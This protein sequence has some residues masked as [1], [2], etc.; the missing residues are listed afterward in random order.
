MGRTTK[1]LVLALTFS[2]I[3]AVP[4][5]QA[6]WMEDGVP[7]CS[8]VNNQINVE[9]ISDGSGGA[10]ITWE[11][12]GAGSKI[13]VQRI[14]NLGAVQWTENGKEICSNPAGQ[15]GQDLVLDDADGA[16][17][18]WTD[19][20]NGSLLSNPDIF[21]QRIDADGDTVWASDGVAIC[22]APGLQIV[23]RI[24]SDGAGGAIITWPDKRNG[25][26]DVYAQ[27]IDASGAVL[28][29]ADGDTVCVASG[30]Q[31]VPQIVSDDAGGAII[32]WTD[33]RNG[34]WDPYAQRIDGDCNGMWAPDGVPLCTHDSLQ[35]NEHIASDGAGNVLVTWAD[36]RNG[37]WD[38]YAQKID[39]SGVVHWGTNGT[40]VCT[41]SNDQEQPR[42]VTDD[43]GGAIIVWRDRRNG[44]S[45]IYAQ[46]LDAVVGIYKWTLDG[47]AVCTGSDSQ[48][49][50][51]AVADD[52]G[53][54]IVT[55][56]DERSGDVLPEDI[57]AQ[58]IDKD[59]NILW[60][61]AGLAVCTADWHQY[62]PEIASNGAGGA[63]I[64]WE[65][66]RDLFIG[67]D[68]DIYAQ[69]IDRHGYWGYPTPQILEIDDVPDDQGGKISIIWSAAQL[70]YYPMSIITHYSIWR[71]LSYEES[72]ALFE[73]Q[74]LTPILNGE[75]NQ[76]E[77]SPYRMVQQGA[78]SYAWEWIAD[79]P[80]HHFETYAYTV[81]SLY[82]SM[83]TDP[84][85]QH[86][87]VSAQ[88]G[89]VNKY[90]DSPVDS[91]YS[92]DNLPPGQ[93][94]GLAGEQSYVPEGLQL[95]WSHNTETD[96]WHYAV[97]RGADGNFVPGPGNIIS[98]PPDTAYFDGDWRWD[99]GFYYKVSAIDVHG[100]ES[101]FSL[102]RPIDITGDDTPVTPLATFLEQNYPNPFNPQTTIAFG[103]KESAEVSLRI[104]DAAGRLVRTLVSEKRTAAHYEEVWDGRDNH[105][106]AVASGVYFYSL[107]AGSFKE[108][109]KM[110]LLR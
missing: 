24:T 79:V 108:T 10:I 54:A 22:T 14:D 6:K 80:A 71:R 41:A 97:Y 51:R 46:R 89:I 27:R 1:L 64:A 66:W 49:I 31:D 63:I 19:T 53:G 18:T 56:V 36:N 103:L 65:D 28:W 110:V 50:P 35:F 25:Y 90:W 85:W 44:G 45:E 37:N 62:S 42:I 33:D 100:N 38:I 68:S 40:A 20:R 2:C 4:S 8:L 52:A 15:A 98:S 7:I 59:G 107:S 74:S 3:L 94:Q 60:G 101:P 39:T 96:L 104:Y 105:G 86:F 87:M 13:Y 61:S 91:G 106:L 55:W 76:L 69:G 21:A 12:T 67:H 58:K 17:I 93:T 82:D 9:I 78:N 26:S 47:I 57:Y 88:T 77:K 30:I 23:S 29:T 95:T 102:L 43:A 5:L 83:G 84:H 48:S 75:T 34:N 32:V 81:P 73:Q 109:K 70:D 92:V 99:S 11:D 16:I 72:L